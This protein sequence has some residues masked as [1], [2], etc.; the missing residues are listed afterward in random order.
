VLACV[1][2]KPKAAQQ[3]SSAGAGG[4]EAMKADRLKAAAEARQAK[5]LAKARAAQ[6]REAKKRE[7]AT[8]RERKAEEKRKAAEEKRR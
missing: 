7:A 6:E 1:L 2:Q 4:R 5:E 8:E 3:A